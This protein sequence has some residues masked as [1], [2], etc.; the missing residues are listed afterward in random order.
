MAEERK[1]YY[2]RS[3]LE[4]PKETDHSEDQGIG[5]RMESE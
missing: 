5:G 1:I 4:I 2:T 3:W